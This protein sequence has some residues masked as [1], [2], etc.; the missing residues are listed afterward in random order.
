MKERA[1]TTKRIRNIIF[2]SIANQNERI[3]PHLV[4]TTTLESTI[5]RQ[6]QQVNLLPP[7]PEKNDVFLTFQMN[8]KLHQMEINF[9]NDFYIDDGSISHSIL[10][11][12]FETNFSFYIK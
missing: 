8:I 10:H 3:I 6:C 11:K 12:I 2:Q 7:I 9:N 5:Q 1:D 4:S